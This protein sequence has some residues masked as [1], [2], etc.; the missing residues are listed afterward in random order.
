M[1]VFL[2]RHAK[3]E[4]RSDWDGPDALRP[5]SHAGLAQA[6]AIAR[7]LRRERIDRIVSSPM[8]R[9]LQTA[10]PL[11]LRTGAEIE[12]VDWL[13]KDESPQKAADA[14]ARMRARRVVCFTHAELVRHL[15]AELTERGI[16]VERVS[17]P[18]DEATTDSESRR[19]AVMDL[20]ST[21]FHMLVADVTRGGRLTAVDRERV[22]LRLGAV[23]ASHD[24]IPRDVAK[25]AVDTAVRLKERALAIG[26]EE[27]IAVGTAAL[28]DADN[29][30]ELCADLEHATGGSVR[31]LSGEEEARIIFE[32]FRRRVRLPE[33]LVLG[34]DLGGGSLELAIGDRQR[35]VFETTLPVGAARLHRQF[36]T[37]DPLRKREL[38]ALC[39]HVQ[40]ALAPWR[41]E[42]AA[43]A[44]VGAVAAGGTAR[45]LG[46]LVVGLRGMRPAG[47]INEMLI[48]RAA[49]DEAT[50]LLAKAERAE[51]LALPGMR[52]RRVDLLP[53]GALVLK[54]VVDELGL[55]GF[56]LTDW[57][58]REGVLLD[59]IGA[60]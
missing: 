6:D 49:L 11:G 7:T 2:I 4:K 10:A 15:A 9:C 24:R 36:V 42:I 8:R 54:T 13:A 53:V 60:A 5:L 19:L 3:A 22:M 56:T 1:R 35:V 17:R 57:G 46:H 16:R 44:P 50:G 21:S 59:E 43:H 14:I 55:D 37:R 25:R 18:S 32:S 33:G 28:R 30:R 52:R 38:R 31:I 12:S 29:G 27:V 20:G 26:A 23:I 34:L 45:A 47:T 48:D 39:D 58:L 51:R 41:E 40:E